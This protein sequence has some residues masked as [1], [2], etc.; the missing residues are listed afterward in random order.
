MLNYHK[1]ICGWIIIEIHLVLNNKYTI[2]ILFTLCI[3]K[4]STALEIEESLEE[5]CYLKSVKDLNSLKKKIIN[6]L[7]DN[8][9][10][11]TKE[12]P[13]NR[14]VYEWIQRFWQVPVT[15]EFR[16]Y[17]HCFIFAFEPY[18]QAMIQRLMNS[19]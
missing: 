2:Y 12:T 16:E 5:A 1:N 17:L 13:M 19:K 10:I 14:I 11:I 9:I 7:S 4:N 8:R 18:Q 15:V 6:R 3:L